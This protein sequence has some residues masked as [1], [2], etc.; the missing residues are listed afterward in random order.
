MGLL[1]VVLNAPVGASGLDLFPD[2]VGWLLV[3]LG[4]R[5]LPDGVPLR[6]VLFA[7]SVLTGMVSAVLWVPAT[8]AVLDGIDPA[9][10]W[11]LELPRV[12]FLVALSL[13]LSRAADTAGDA[14]AR[15]WWRLT[16]VAAVLTGLFPVLVYGAGVR[17]LAEVA[18]GVAVATL[19]TCLA[20]CLAHSARAWTH[21]GS[22]RPA[23][24]GA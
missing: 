22:D 16:L 9:L 12:G 20:L 19:L 7:T 8:A 2:P 15:G 5:T 23:P 13:A 6:G 1:L 11:G 17:S 24:S 3:L 14:R 10:Q 18:G 4:V 21:G